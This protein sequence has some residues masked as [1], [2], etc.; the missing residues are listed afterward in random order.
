MFCGYLKEFGM[1]KI[2][3]DKWSKQVFPVYEMQKFE[4]SK[5]VHV[6][7]EKLKKLMF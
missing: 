4:I 6:N 1:K 5:S 3:D 2:H 7:L